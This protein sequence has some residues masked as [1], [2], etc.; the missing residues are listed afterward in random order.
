MAAAAA[1]R[2]DRIVIGNQ[3]IPEEDPNAPQGF[4]EATD[5]IYAVEPDGTGSFTVTFPDAG[6]TVAIFVI[7]NRREL[8]ISPITSSSTSMAGE[9]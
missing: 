7:R 1:S 2:G 5:C 8:S 3:D 9:R 6:P 4:R